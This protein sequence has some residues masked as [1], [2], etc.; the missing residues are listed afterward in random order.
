M[1]VVGET[2]VVVVSEAARDQQREEVETGKC[3]Q[4]KASCMC[5]VGLQLYIR[6]I[7]MLT[8]GSGGG[9]NHMYY[10]YVCEC[11]RQSMSQWSEW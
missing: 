10:L 8:Y 2:N 3:L 9:E 6:Q 1:S 11:R 7:M 4:G 5:K